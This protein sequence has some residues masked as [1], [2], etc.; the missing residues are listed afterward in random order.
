MRFGSVR[1]GVVVEHGRLVVAALGRG[2]A[3]VFRVEADQPAE[4]L[5][6]E[7]AAR[8]LTSRAVAL[9][10]PRA[11]VFVKPVELPPVAGDLREMVRFELERHLPVSPEDAAFD[12]L[13]LRDDAGRPAGAERRV[14]VAATDRA[15]VERA[16]RLAQE[17]R[18]R[19]RSL[20]VAAHELLA[21]VTLPSRQ[22]IVWVHGASGATDVLFVHDARLVLS[23]SLP[24]EAAGR[25]ADEIAQS[26]AL[27]RWPACDAVWTSG[28]LAD[29]IEHPGAAAL[30]ALAA[31]V[32]E[33]PFTARARRYL[34]AIETASAG[35]SQLAVAVAAARGARPLDLLPAPLRPRRITRAQAVTA[36]VAAVAV[37][38]SA[39]ALL[40]PGIREGR[41]LAAIDAAIAQL[42]PEVRAVERVA[43]RLEER[44]RL[45][46]TVAEL[47]ASGLRPLPV[48]RE[49]TELVPA[50]AWLTMLTL[51]ARGA[52]LTGQAAAASALIPLLE[53]SPRL[54]GAEFASPVTRGRE[55]EQFRIRAAWQG[56]SVGRAL[57]L[58]A[59]GG[60]RTPPRPPAT[61]DNDDEPSDDTP[62]GRP[63]A[64]P[65][66]APRS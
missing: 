33:P 10:L 38:L 64:R 26:L 65:A 19:P 16:V 47:G 8:G 34:A 1:L 42:D 30:G 58:P 4:A 37:A 53:N 62:A 39:A 28:D 43:R 5:R 61:A 35:A 20:T 2:S 3:E 51:D 14:L 7:L 25:L 46:A 41:H 6:A 50:D 63:P 13:P 31:P 32:A 36:A 44:R 18:L 54:T 49:L 48:L 66:A 9:A 24:P 12:V 52:E 60:A 56:G 27:L 45:L 59:G 23:R 17:A 55:R 29:P 57:A 15:R 40:A 11:A 22:R 21:L